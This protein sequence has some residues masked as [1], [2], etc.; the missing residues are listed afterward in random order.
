VRRFAKPDVSRERA[1]EY[2]ARLLYWAEMGSEPDHDHPYRR[3]LAAIKSGGEV[4]VAGWSIGNEP[5]H[6]MFVLAPVR[7]RLG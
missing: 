5:P 1:A 3:K 4:A 2:Y 7:R 6:E